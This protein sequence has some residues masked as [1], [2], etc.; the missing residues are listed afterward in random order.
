MKNTLLYL[1]LATLASTAAAADP[2]APTAEQ[3]AFFENK[4]RPILVDNCYR[5]H[6]AAEG[7]SKGGLMLDTRAG[8][9]KGG[10][11]GPAIIPGKPEDSL[12]IKAV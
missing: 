11:T 9:E 5:C 3:T 1:G 7:K 2:T 6:S 8:W 12:L 10:D 4:I